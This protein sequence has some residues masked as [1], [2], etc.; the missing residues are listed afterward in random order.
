MGDF[1]LRLK[2]QTRAAHDRV[3]AGFGALDISRRSDFTTFLRGQ[4]I[5]HI[6]T[7]ASYPPGE[8]FPALEERIK[9][10]A[11]DLR[12]LGGDAARP[13]PDFIDKYVKTDPNHPLGLTYV[14]AGSLHGTNVLRKMWAKAADDVVLSADNFM[15]FSG[16]NPEWAEVI[17]ALKTEAFSMV[18]ELQIIRTVNYTFDLFNAGL[19]LAMDSE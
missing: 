7:Q 5:G 15:N 14:I 4:H 9:A 11:A 16:L 18:D 17:S 1:R 2:E 6:L 19:R 12:V 13:T 3:D 10:I 8:A